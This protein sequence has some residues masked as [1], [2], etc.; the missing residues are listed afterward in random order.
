MT[1]IVFLNS[2]AQALLTRLHRVKPFALQMTSVPA[3]A[4]SLQAQE[5]IERVLAHGRRELQQRVRAFRE[6]LKSAS[7]RLATA[8][9]A[10]RR[11]TL[12][13]LRFNAVLTQV[14]LF[15]DARRATERT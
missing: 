1:A 4:V 3:A 6:W 13:R 10:Q 15:A 14:D 7:G 5:A 2:E 12:L 9:D 8:A 11:F